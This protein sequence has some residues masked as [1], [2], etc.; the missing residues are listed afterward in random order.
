MPKHKTPTPPTP[1]DP[2]PHPDNIPALATKV[3]HLP[4][5][6]KL[7]AIPSLYHKAT[8]SIISNANHKL[9]DMI[10]IKE[11]SLYKKSPKRYHADLKTAAGFQPRAMDQ[12]NLAPTRDPDTLEITSNPQTIVETIQSH[13]EREHARTTPDTIPAPP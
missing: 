5:T 11:D 4:D 2:G 12:P 8:A 3:L 7:K 9:M 13:Y 1:P 6:P 10:R